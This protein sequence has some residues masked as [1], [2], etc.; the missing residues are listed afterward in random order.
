MNDVEWQ[1]LR[2]RSGRGAGRNW[3]GVA[4]DERKGNLEKT[5]GA[6]LG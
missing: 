4:E 6:D 5:A 1:A 3:D 2:E